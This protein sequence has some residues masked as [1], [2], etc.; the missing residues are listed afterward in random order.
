MRDSQVD[1]QRGAISRK[2]SKTQQVVNVPVVTY[3]LWPQTIELLRHHRSGQDTVLLTRSG[4]PWACRT[5]DDQGKLHKNDN[6]APNFRRLQ[7]KTGLWLSTTPLGGMSAEQ[8]T[9]YS[10]CSHVG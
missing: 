10:R 9:V 5:L 6:I 8:P 2:R 7:R 4:G 3:R 1:W